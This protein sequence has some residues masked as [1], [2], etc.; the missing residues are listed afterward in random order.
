MFG[1]CVPPSVGG[2]PSQGQVVGWLT[3][4]DQIDPDDLK[5]YD[6]PHDGNGIKIS[7]SS[8]HCEGDYC[9][10]TCSSF[11]VVSQRT[12]NFAGTLR[13]NEASELIL[14]DI[15]LARSSQLV[16]GQWVS[17]RTGEFSFWFP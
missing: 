11:E 14:E 16:D 17:M 13:L 7:E 9:K 1:G 5:D 6:A 8:F 15:D 3:L 12:Y 4:Y 2:S 10:T